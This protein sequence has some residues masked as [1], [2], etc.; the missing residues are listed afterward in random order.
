MG[1]ADCQIYK[2]QNKTTVKRQK[3]EKEGQKTL[4]KT[5]GNGTNCNLSDVYSL[6]AKHLKI[7]Q[8]TTAMRQKTKKRDKKRC[9]RQATAEQTQPM[10]AV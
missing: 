1:A 6:T 10:F 3:R 9:R 2:N 7:K 5:V 4:P 8:K